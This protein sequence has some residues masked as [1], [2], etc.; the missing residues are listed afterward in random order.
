[1]QESGCA[2]TITG[3]GAI[4]IKWRSYSFKNQA[5]EVKELFI[6]QQSHPSQWLKGSDFKYSLIV[7]ILTK[8]EF[9]IIYRARRLLTRLTISQVCS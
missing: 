7:K 1:M 2:L 5:L 4:N 6:N 3:D 8:I 9:G